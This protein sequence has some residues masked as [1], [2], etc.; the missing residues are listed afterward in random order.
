MEGP[1]VKILKILQSH[2]NVSE[3]QIKEF[4]YRNL[5]QEMINGLEYDDPKTIQRVLKMFGI[6]KSRAD[7]EFKDDHKDNHKDDHKDDHEAV[8]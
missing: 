4:L 8:A 5:S 1:P 7:L 3:E 2:K 6:E